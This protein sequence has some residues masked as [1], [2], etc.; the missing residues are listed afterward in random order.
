[1]GPS[2][3]FLLILQVKAI[4]LI[5]LKALK[6]SINDF[7]NFMMDEILSMMEIEEEKVLRVSIK[8]NEKVEIC[9]TDE[10]SWNRLEQRMTQMA[11]TDRYNKYKIYF[12]ID[13][14]EPLRVFQA[15]NLSHEI[16]SS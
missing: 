2:S 13:D 5:T 11:K 14:E 9:L 12:D 16:G 1:M 10:E 3:S 8:N 7:E 15:M 4:T 6:E